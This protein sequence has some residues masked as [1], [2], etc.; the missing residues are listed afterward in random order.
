MTFD[1]GP[2]NLVDPDTVE[3]LG[4][5]IGRI[6]EDPHLTVVVFRSE[7]PGYF[8]AHWDLLADPARVAKMPPGRTFLGPAPGGGRG[9][10]VRVR[11]RLAP[12]TG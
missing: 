4:T 3:Q 8:M 6:E 12:W 5:L 1:N 9:G 2:I 10:C 11:A 7:K